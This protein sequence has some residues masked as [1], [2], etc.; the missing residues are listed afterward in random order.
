MGHT[1]PEKMRYKKAERAAEWGQDNNDAHRKKGG[2][3]ARPRRLWKQVTDHVMALQVPGHGL[4]EA[5][6]VRGGFLSKANKICRLS[7]S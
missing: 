4:L 7:D 6:V 3:S 5:E 2:N 1:H